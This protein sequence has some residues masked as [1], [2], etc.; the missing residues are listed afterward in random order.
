M[1]ET[2][3]H[4]FFECRCMTQIWKAPPF[5][6]RLPSETMGFGAWLR[7]LRSNLEGEALVVACIVCWRIWWWRNQVVHEEGVELKEDIVEWAFHFLEA[8]KT[9]QLPRISRSQAGPEVWQPPRHPTVKVNFDVGFFE[10]NRYQIAV[11]A[12]NGGGGVLWW[13]VRRFWGAPPV[14]VGE[15]RA[16]LEG[17]RLAKEKGWGD[18][19]IEGDNSE[20][21]S[22]L[23]NR[24]DDPKLVYGALISSCLILVPL[25]QS[26]SSSLVKRSG[27]K[28]AHALAHFSL[29]SSNF[30]AGC[31]IPADL[32]Y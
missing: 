22:A 30:L 31:D 26:F 15:A 32:A 27:N 2:T 16:A 17:L 25:F 11:V 14:V 29:V 5:H 7:W 3:A 9:A 24:V 1:E 28:L 21:I 8:Y 6:L 13:Q 23:Q 18:I 19:V 12:R 4:V 10:D 20:V